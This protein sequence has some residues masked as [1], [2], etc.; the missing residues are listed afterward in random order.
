M[1][2]TMRLRDDP[3]Q[4]IRA[5][6][7]TFELRLYD[8]KRKQVRAGDLIEFE[9]IA[10]GEKLLAEVIS[11]HVFS[12]FEELYATLPLLSCGYTDKTVHT[13]HY[14]D[15][16]AYYSKAEQAQY[17]VVGIRVRLLAG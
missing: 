9:N 7:K 10:T 5:G 11:L 2:H 13:A 8:E 15:M 6:I 12:N 1:R 14:T 17:G 16:E 4:K 3:Y